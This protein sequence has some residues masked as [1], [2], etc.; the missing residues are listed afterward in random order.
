MKGAERAVILAHGGWDGPFTT[1][2]LAADD[3]SLAYLKAGGRGG[4]TRAM[5]NGGAAHAKW[6]NALQEGAE[7]CY[8]GIPAMISPSSCHRRDS[9]HSSRWSRSRRSSRTEPRARP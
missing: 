9:R 1:E 7:S 5:S 4:V 2:P 8:Y 6:T 3:A